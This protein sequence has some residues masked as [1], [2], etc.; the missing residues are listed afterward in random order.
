MAVVALADVKAHLRVTG[1]TDDTL[2]TSQIDAAES[3][4]DKIGVAVAAPIDPPVKQAVFLIVEGFYRATLTDHRLRAES[5]EGIG[6]DQYWSPE[7]LDAARLRT[8]DRLI[9]PF[10]ENNL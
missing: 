2:L 8:V 9:A 1:S 4:L 7:T 3:Y 6:Q 10:R 5:V